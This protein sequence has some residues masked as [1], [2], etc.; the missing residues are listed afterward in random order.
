MFYFVTIVSSPISGHYWEESAAS[1][2]PHNRYLYTLLRCLWVFSTKQ[3][4]PALIFQKKP[5]FPHVCGP[6][7][8]SVNPCFLY[9][10]RP[11][12]GCS[13]PVVSLSRGKG[14]LPTIQLI[15]QPRILF[16]TL[17]T[18]VP[19]CLIVSLLSARTLSPSVQI[20]LPAGWSP[21]CTDPLVIP[22]QVQDS[23]FLW[24]SC[25]LSSPA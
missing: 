9:F 16:P 25:L 3:I 21:V 22:S 17:G 11:K 6:I 10:W 1:L 20:C 7:L 24:Q 12:T 23:A 5:Q 18:P 4:V 13:C 15:L 19:G 14:S 2:F 8:D